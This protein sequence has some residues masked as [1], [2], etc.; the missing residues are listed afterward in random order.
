MFKHGRFPKGRNFKCLVINILATFYIL[1][2]YIYIYIYV[3][4]YVYVYVCMYIQILVFICFASF[5]IASII[6]MNYET[7]M[8]EVKQGWWCTIWYPLVSSHAHPPPTPPLIFG[9]FE[10]WT[11]R[12]VM[13]KLLRNRGVC[14]KRGVL[15]ERG[16]SK[17]FHQFSLKKACFHYYWNFCL[18]NIHTCCNQ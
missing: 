9:K 4:V 11:K 6:K 17:L 14:W 18:V 13:K 8:N 16:I 1:Y 10:I 15:L 7:R 3:C 12:E 5:I 2:I